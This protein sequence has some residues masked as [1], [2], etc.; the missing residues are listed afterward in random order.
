MAT[1]GPQDC[2]VELLSCDGGLHLL[3]APRGIP[4]AHRFQ[5]DLIRSTGF[6]IE[7]RVTAPDGLAGR[8]IR[9]WLGEL[10]QWHFSR[11]QPPY[12]GQLSNRTDEIP[13]GCLQASLFIPEDAWL[14]AVHCLGTIWRELRLKGVQGEDGA[15]TILEFSFSSGLRT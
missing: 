9:I 11:R 5:G 14:P 4:K 3:P 15:V 2:V 6:T 1:D 13:G 10:K 7:G 12:I 8:R